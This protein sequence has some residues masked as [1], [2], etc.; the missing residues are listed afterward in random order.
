M[1]VK[2]RASRSSKLAPW[3]CTLLLVCGVVDAATLTELFDR[4]DYA[5][6]QARAQAAAAKGDA[7]ALFLLGKAAHLGKGR[8]VDLAEAMKRYE[9]ARAKGSARASNNIGSIML[10]Q[11]DREGSIPLFEE[12]LSRGLK[13]PTLLNLGRAYTPPDPT[14]FIDL[15]PFSVQARKAGDYLAQ[16]F[17]IQPDFETSVDTARQYLRAYLIGIKALGE[18]SDLELPAVRAL[19]V[20]WMKRGMDADHGPSWTNYGALLLDEDDYVGARAALEKGAAKK[21]PTAMFH[22]GNMA[23]DGKGLA[24]PDQGLA[25][26]YFEQAALLGLE[27]ARYP[28]IQLL[29]K[30]I[31]Y[32][33]DAAKLE[34]GIAR[35]NALRK[36]E[37]FAPLRPPEER[38]A[39]LRYLET[40]K[41]DAVPTPPLPIRFK[42]CEL[43]INGSY[44]LEYNIGENTEW[45]LVAFQKLGEPQELGV[46]GRVSEQ[47]CATVEKPLSDNVRSLMDAGAVIALWFPNYTLPLEWKADGKSVWLKLMP[48]GT[49]PIPDL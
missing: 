26:Q 40:A 12:A 29:E 42:A 9:E 19:A 13:M 4:E 1:G 11:G 25:L 34:Q 6:F 10:E 36:A 32:T 3:L 8:E 27:Q 31:E 33:T 47:G 22:L 37:D 2:M 41:R 21:V 44:G 45:R 35:L 16:A 17:A 48:L 38:L 28:A 5:A 43:G 24:A 18:N 20:Q 15:Y 39:W 14:S 46:E 23:Q 7:E 30:S 49:A